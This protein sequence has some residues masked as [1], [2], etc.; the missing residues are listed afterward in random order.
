MRMRNK[1]ISC[2]SVAKMGICHFIAIFLNLGRSRQ[3]QQWSMQIYKFHVCKQ[4][5]VDIQH[6]P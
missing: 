2:P 4:S 3:C 6:K 5:Y 1:K